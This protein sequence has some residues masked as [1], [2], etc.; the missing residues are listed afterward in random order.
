M[1]QHFVTPWVLGSALGFALLAHAGDAVKLDVKLGLWEVTTHGKAGGQIPDEMLQ[2][3]PPER[4]E[5]MIAQ[6]RAA[7]EKPE[8]H[9]QCLT[10]AKLEKGFDFGHERASCHRT[11]DSNTSSAMAITETCNEDQGTQ[12]VKARFEA[13]SKEHVSGTI[14]MVM[15]RGGQTMTMD[16]DFQAKWLGADCGTVK[17]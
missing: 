13:V 4:R 3:L 7:A 9:R 10:A 14:N 17:E 16:R 5:A 6:M 15:T 1:K 12:V 2:R 8:T 11:V